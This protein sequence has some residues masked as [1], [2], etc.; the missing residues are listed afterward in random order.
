M[1]VQVIF[2]ISTGSLKVTVKQAVPKSVE[3]AQL[4]DSRTV[5]VA[6]FIEAVQK[7]ETSEYLFDWS[8]PLH[9]PD[10]AKEFVI[11]NYFDGKKINFWILLTTKMIII[12]V[13]LSKIYETHNIVRG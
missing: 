2:F 9:C 12:M 3:W 8:L 10:L 6:E 13:E 7:N 11:P 4:E 5:V 1:A